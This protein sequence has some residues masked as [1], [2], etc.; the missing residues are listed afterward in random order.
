MRL[1][2][3]PGTQP[4]RRQLCLDPTEEQA[5]VLA[6]I[7]IQACK[8]CFTST[9]R[10]N[11]DVLRHL[12][13]IQCIPTTCQLTELVGNGLQLSIGSNSLQLVLLQNGLVRNAV[14]MIEGLATLFSD[15]SLFSKS[16]PTK[17]VKPKTNTKSQSTPITTPIPTQSKTTSRQLEDTVT[18]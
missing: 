5:R 2:H 11:P 12:K 7:S 13:G 15:T 18:N 10:T 14:L 3:G 6:T 4:L 8:S 1:K 9:H 16:C 17:P